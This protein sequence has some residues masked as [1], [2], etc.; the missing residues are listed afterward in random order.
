MTDREPIILNV[1]LSNML[2]SNAM[3]L[4]IALVSPDSLFIM[5]PISFYSKNLISVYIIFFI[6]NTNTP[7]AA[8]RFPTANIKDLNRVNSRLTKLIKISDLLK[9]SIIRKIGEPDT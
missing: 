6:I 9:F 3:L 2:P 4:S 8:V 1:V 7:L 5:L